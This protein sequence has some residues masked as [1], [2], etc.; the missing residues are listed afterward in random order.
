M[1]RWQY[2]GNDG[3]GMFFLTIRGYS[4]EAID[5]LP[6]TQAMKD[7][8]D[9]SVVGRDQTDKSRDALSHRRWLPAVYNFGGELIQV[10]SVYPFNGFFALT[11]KVLDGEHDAEAMR[12]AVEAVNTRAGV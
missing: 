3:E 5:S 7:T 8:L 10:A 12:Q 9:D 11:C 4:K 2:E 6:C 1:S